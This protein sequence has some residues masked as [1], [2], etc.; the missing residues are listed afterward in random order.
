MKKL[1][2]LVL[3]LLIATS[4]I[5]NNERKAKKLIKKYLKTTLNDY[6]SY[7]P[8]E[9]S[10]LDPVYSRYYQDSTYIE[11]DRIQSSNLD[12]IKTFEETIEKAN[13]FN[14]RAGRIL[15]RR[16]ITSEP[17]LKNARIEE[18]RLSQKMKIFRNNYKSKMAGFSMVHKMRAKNTMGGIMI[19][20]KIFFFDKELTKATG[21]MD[22]DDYREFESQ[23]NI[24][25][26]RMK[27]MG[28]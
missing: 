13:E 4:C 23:F 18:D 25:Q 14:E 8:M 21:E 15:D 24:L 22:A 16:G 2:S 11:L 6:S 26:R 1:L 7:D 28:L 5:N 10:K 9:F 19:Y 20:E 17:Y 27:A 12:L 3:A